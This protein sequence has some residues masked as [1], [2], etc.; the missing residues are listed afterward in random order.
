[1]QRVFVI[2]ILICI[3]GCCFA[4]QTPD[5]ARIVVR[6]FNET[7]IRQY[8][9]DSAFQYEPAN[10]TSQSSWDRF[11]MWIWYKIEEITSRPATARIL[12]FLS[13]AIASALLLFFV[14]RLAGMNKAGLFG[15]RN[16]GD[17]LQ[18]IASDEDIHAI[19]FNQ[20]LQQ[21]I[22][23]RNYRLAIRLLY[24]QSLK[25]MADRSL[26]QWQINKTNSAYVSELQDPSQQKDFYR[27]TFQ[28]ENNWYGN[29][30]VPEHEFISVREQ[31]EAFNR[32]LK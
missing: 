11:W 31:F 1:M 28:F 3:H 10:E 21:A 2:L 29:M 25:N 20:A 4:Q 13:I 8:K 23:D 12:K 32:Q 7:T 24:L 16:T 18:F 27:L 6:S 17:S 26:I 14:I 30:P 9:S 15:K 22:D 5:T 19:N